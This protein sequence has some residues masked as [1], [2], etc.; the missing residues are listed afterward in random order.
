MCVCACVQ[1]V[2][3]QAILVI[4]NV[5]N[6]CFPVLYTASAVDAADGYGLSNKSL[7]EFLLKR[8]GVRLY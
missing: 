5:L 2:R 7:Y 6:N 4:T 3:P 1:C 8:V